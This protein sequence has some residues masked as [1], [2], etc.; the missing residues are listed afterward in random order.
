MQR[1]K[2]P[3]LENGKSTFTLNSHNGAEGKD[4]KALASNVLHKVHLAIISITV[5][6][7]CGIQYDDRN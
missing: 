6:R 2:H 4:S 5:R 1:A 3:V 7:P